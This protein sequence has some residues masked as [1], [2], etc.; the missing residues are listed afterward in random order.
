M[1]K[2]ELYSILRNGEEV[3]S[4]LTQGEYFEIMQDYAIEFYK[5]GHPREDELK[6]V[7][8]TEDYGEIEDRVDKS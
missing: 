2:Q 7:I 5:T 3:F 8:T 6:T 1:K 4:D